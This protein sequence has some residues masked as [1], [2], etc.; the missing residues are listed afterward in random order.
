MPMPTI[1]LG[2]MRWVIGATLVACAVIA[3][4]LW[5]RKRGRVT[6]ESD[7][8]RCTVLGR[9][10]QDLFVGKQLTLGMTPEKTPDRDKLL[11]AFWG[12][13]VDYNEG[14]LALM[15][16]KL[17]SSAFALLRPTMEALI[18]AH[19]V[20]FKPQSIVDDIIADRYQTQFRTVGAEIDSAFN[21]KLPGAAD[22]LFEH[23]LKDKNVLHSFTHSGMPQLGRR[24]NG[25]N[26]E[27]N[28]EPEE[29][30]N[31]AHISTSALALVTIL[32]AAQFGLKAE[33][34]EANRLYVEWGSGAAAAP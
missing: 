31:F 27:V 10:L 17:Y 24:F 23:F 3:W 14:M 20:L 7:I 9:R 12:L 4:K 29:V 8:E 32:L 28:F 22:G 21:Y 11:T 18:R 26:L 19:V 1:R 2:P 13:I 6:V 16:E 34:Q 33:A 25:A 15:R 30:I 5:A